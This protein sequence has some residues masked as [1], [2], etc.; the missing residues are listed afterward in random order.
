MAMHLKRGDILAL[1]GQWA[2]AEAHYRAALAL[3]EAQDYPQG[4]AESLFRLGG[5]GRSQGHYAD[6]GIHLLQTTRC[7][8]PCKPD[9]GWR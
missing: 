3:A 1:I 9:R 8:I 4:I 5:W 2:E 7:S 6:A